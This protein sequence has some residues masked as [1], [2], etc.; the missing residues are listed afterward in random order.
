MYYLSCIR[1]QYQAHY[2]RS[3]EERLADCPGESTFKTY[4]DQLFFT[5]WSLKSGL[6][7]DMMGY[8]I[9]IEPSNVKRNQALGVKI[10]SEAL[11]SIDCMPKRSF[12]KVEEFQEYFDEH[13]KLILDGTEQRVQRPKNKE[14]QKSMYSGKKKSHTV[15]CL[16]ISTSDKYIH[17][18]SKCWV[19]KKS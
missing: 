12:E 15:K 18:V 6:G 13:K 10:L 1:R 5:L 19:G 2:G 11:Q 7:Y 4:H 8:L 16:I 17:Y 9:G 14:N 3:I